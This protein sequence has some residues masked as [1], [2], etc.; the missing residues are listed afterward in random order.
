MDKQ[1]SSSNNLKMTTSSTTGES[2]QLSLS[3][4]FVLIMY[5]NLNRLNPHRLYIDKITF[6]KLKLIKTRKNAFTGYWL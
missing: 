1:T 2:F 5:N 3:S 4:D 6:F